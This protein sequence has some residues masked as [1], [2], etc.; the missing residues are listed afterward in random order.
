MA[1]AQA[2]LAQ[3]TFGHKL[4]VEAASRSTTYSRL[5]EIMAARRPVLCAFAMAA[6]GAWMLSAMFA[7][8]AP[9][10]GFVSSLPALRTTSAPAVAPATAL[11]ALPEPRPNEEMLPVD[12]NRTSLYWGLLTITILSVLF[13][14]Y[15]FN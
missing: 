2:F 8:S 6:V 9:E 13:S 12:L 11:R 14:S 15:F 7:P 5:L 4:F 3:E 1:L 10:A